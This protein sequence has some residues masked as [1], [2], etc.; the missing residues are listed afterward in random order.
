M[1][2]I[3]LGIVTSGYMATVWNICSQASDRNQDKSR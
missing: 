2:Y 3:E 1:G